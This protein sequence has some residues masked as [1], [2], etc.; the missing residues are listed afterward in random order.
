MFRQLI[1][2]F[3]ILMEM[4]IPS[5]KFQPT[6]RDL[7]KDILGYMMDG[8]LT[9]EDKFVL[10]MTCHYFSRIV[11]SEGISGGSLIN[12]F[13]NNG[14][15]KLV[16]WAYDHGYRVDELS[17]ADAVFSGNVEIIKWVQ[18]HG[19]QLN[20]RVLMNAAEKGQFEFLKWAKSQVVIYI[21]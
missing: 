10:Q 15:I 20:E 21:F 17:A 9:Q 8:F 4:N 3:I 13:I 14:W 18:E 12:Y 19:C 1:I 5:V 11:K 2:Y 6:L 16:Q 7:P